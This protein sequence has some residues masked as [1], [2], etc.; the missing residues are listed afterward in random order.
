MF[1]M[2]R[3]KKVR[4]FK[5]KTA[6]KT[7]FRCESYALL[8]K[9]INGNQ[10]TTWWCKLLYEVTHFYNDKWGSLLQI[11]YACKINNSKIKY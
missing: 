11:K 3:S 8:K 9:C 10:M 2:E 4:W 1:W 7:D 5:K 6:L